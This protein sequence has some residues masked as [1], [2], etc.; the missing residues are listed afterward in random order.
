M[1]VIVNDGDREVTYANNNWFVLTGHSHVDNFK[2]V[3]WISMIHEDDT[4]LAKSMWPKVC[5]GEPAHA[6]LRLKSWWKD[7]HG[8]PFP[9]WVMTTAWPEMENGSLKQVIGTMID[10]SHLKFA[11]G[12]QTSRIEQ[13]IEAKRQQEK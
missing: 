3:D 2:D 5:A 13:A 9:T 7:A 12:V 4:E 10:I 11:E 6:E 8:S 1:A